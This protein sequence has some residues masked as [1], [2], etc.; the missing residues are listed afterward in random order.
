MNRRNVW[1]MYLFLQVISFLFLIYERFQPITVLF[2][3]I[4][5]ILLVPTLFLQRFKG[6]LLTLIAFYLV[7]LKWPEF[8]YFLPGTWCIVNRSQ[9]IGFSWIVLG[10]GLVALMEI[11]GIVKIFVVSMMLFSYFFQTICLEK[12][13]LLQQYLALQDDSWEQEQLLRQKNEELQNTQQA[14]IQLEIAEE[15]NRIARDIH[16]NVGHLLSS[17][18]IQLGALEVLT[19]EAKVQ[20]PLQALKATIHTGMDNIRESV[21]DLHESSLNFQE[22]L[23]RLVDEFQFCS[24]MVQGDFSEQLTSQQKNVLLMVAKEALANVMKH[25]R[26]SEVIIEE[27]ELPAFYRFRIKDNG[28]FVTNKS[29]KGLGLVSMRQRV[30]EIG[31]QLHT[32]AT[33]DGFAVTVIL[34]KEERT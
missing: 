22:S 5:I 16:D 7:S 9:L 13:K 17:A 19:Q 18:I 6:H 2:L 21:H 10:S 3:L 27:L 28:T 24:I 25:S 23:G 12:E 15:R 8:I 29:S 14:M 31:G 20:A 11:S 1:G 4:S 33:K 34:P 30:Q 32:N 26:A